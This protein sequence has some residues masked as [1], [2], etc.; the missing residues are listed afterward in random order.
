MKST[1]RS[2]HLSITLLS[3][4]LQKETGFTFK[5]RNART[6]TVKSLQKKLSNT[7]ILCYR[8]LVPF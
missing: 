2:F 1:F 3:Q 8:K 5:R 6:S 7:R 4:R